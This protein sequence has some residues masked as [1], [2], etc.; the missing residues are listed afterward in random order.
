MVATADAYK[1][2]EALK[3]LAKQFGKEVAMLKQT[4]ATLEKRVTS[5]EKSQT[6]KE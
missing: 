6:P 2:Q 4:V 1:V 5:L 3:E